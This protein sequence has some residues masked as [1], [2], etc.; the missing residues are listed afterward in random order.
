MLTAVSRLRS[1]LSLM[2]LYAVIFIDL[3]FC[4]ATPGT[5]DLASS[6]ARTKWR[7]GG[8][9]IGQNRKTAKSPYALGAWMKYAFALPS[10]AIGF[11]ASGAVFGH[12]TEGGFR[13]GR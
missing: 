8:G 13:L 1:V 2:I 4:H 7:L 11:M 5:M 3:F 9:S 12:G 6:E 10:V